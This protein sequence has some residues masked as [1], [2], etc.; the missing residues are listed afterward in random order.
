MYR[1]ILRQSPGFN[2]LNVFLSKLHAH[3]TLLHT[4]I[5]DHWIE[6]KNIDGNNTVPMP[7]AVFKFLNHFRHLKLMSAIHNFSISIFQQ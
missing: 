1:L 5:H 6:L 3:N 2:V 4:P 7:V